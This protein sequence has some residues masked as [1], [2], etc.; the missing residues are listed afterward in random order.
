MMLLVEYLNWKK[1]KINVNVYCLNTIY[2]VPIIS[3]FNT[4]KKSIYLY[5]ASLA[6]S[7]GGKRRK[8]NVLAG[9]VSSHCRLIAV[10]R[11][12]TVN[13]LMNVYAAQ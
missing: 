3:I 9:L 11:A 12:K 13:V 1:N 4:S 7:K 5:I 8:K 6:R 10:A 2:I